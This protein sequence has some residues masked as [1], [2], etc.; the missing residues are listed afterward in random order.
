MK[1]LSIRQPWADLILSGQKTLELRSWSVSHRGPLAIH[2]SQ[3][4]DEAACREFGIDPRQ[5][6][7]G[8]LLG[9]VELDDIQELDQSSFEVLHPQHKSSAAFQAPLFGWQVKDPQVFAEPIPWR[10]RMGLFNV[11]DDVSA[12]ALD[13]PQESRLVVEDQVSPDSRLPFELQVMVETDKSVSAASYRLALFQRPVTPPNLQPGLAQFVPPP[14][15]MVC[16]LGGIALRSVADAILEALRKNEYAATDLGINRREPFY[17]S[18]ESGVRLALIFLAVQPIRKA[19]RIEE[20]SRGIRAMTAEELYYWFAKCTTNGS[21]DR[22]Q[23]ALR[24]L[25]AEE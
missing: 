10:G 24:L 7:A 4:V 18:E 21:A 15:R 2:A 3:T 9:V 19:L 20:I 13:T 17:L 6:S 5:V 12:A 14:R 11:P 1:A 23:R 22:A 16:E 25:L 8:V